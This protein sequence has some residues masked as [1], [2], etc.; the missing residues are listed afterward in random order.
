M[1]TLSRTKHT[2]KRLAMEH[3]VDITSLTAFK[4]MKEIGLMRPL[5]LGE[6]GK[7]AL[8]E[9]G[10]FYGENATRSRDRNINYGPLFRPDRFKDLAILV[11]NNLLRL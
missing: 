7:T 3:G 5:D 6:K 9:T 1:T 2:W 4:V 10:V 11:Q 8:T